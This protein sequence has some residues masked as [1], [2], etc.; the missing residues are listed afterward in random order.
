LEDIAINIEKQRIVDLRL[1]IGKCETP[2]EFADEFNLHIIETG[3]H[4][5]DLYEGR[6]HYGINILN[7][8]EFEIIE[9]AIEI[10]NIDGN[11]GESKRRDGENYSTFYN[12]YDGLEDYQNNLKSYFNGD[13]YFYKSQET[14]EEF[15]IE[16]I[17]ECTTIDDV[18]SLIEKFDEIESGYYDGNGNIEISD[19]DLNDGD[20]T[21]YRSDIYTFQFC[22]RFDFN[23]YFNSKRE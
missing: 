18:K 2:R 11:Y 14:D 21:G 8:K 19:K 13:N 16:Q 3:N 17:K 9:L 10:H 22:Y 5:S 15:Y 23:K 7:S 6:S 12:K 20:L 4:W 1:R